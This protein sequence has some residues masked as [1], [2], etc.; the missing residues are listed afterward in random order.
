MDMAIIVKG[1]MVQAVYSTSDEVEV[2]VIDLDP[3]VA[4]TPEE[5]LDFDE[6][7]KRA[8]DMKNSDRWLPVW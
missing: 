4:M 8:E 3:P 2:E 6:L 5:A 1:G 7:E